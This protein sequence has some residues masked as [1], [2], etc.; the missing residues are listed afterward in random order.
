MTEKYEEYH[1]YKDLKSLAKIR[2]KR[3]ASKADIDRSERISYG[4]C[5][6]CGK[7]KVM[8]DKSVCEK[9]YEKRIKSMRR[10]MYLPGND[11]WKNNNKLILENGGI[12]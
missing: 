1:F 5:Y 4:I 12:K 10:I 8:G 7:D 6:I 2:N 3:N 11:Y 9:C